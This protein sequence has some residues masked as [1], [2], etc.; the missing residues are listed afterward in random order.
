MHVFLLSG[1]NQ[2]NLNIQPLN[3]N[4]IDYKMCVSLHPSSSSEDELW[5][6]YSNSPPTPWDVILIIPFDLSGIF[7]FCDTMKI[8]VK[9]HSLS[10][11]LWILCVTRMISGLYAVHI[12]RREDCM[13]EGC[14]SQSANFEQFVFK[15]HLG[16]NICVVVDRVVLMIL[17]VVRHKW[18]Q[19]IK[20]A[21]NW[22]ASR[23]GIFFF[24]FS[25]FYKEKDRI[26]I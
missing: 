3:W 16:F 10:L 14:N 18:C 12:F 17:W 24:K 25:E 9:L 8:W 4:K 21:T 5:H 2:C 26:S 22:D 20:M 13:A 23:L 11:G 19:N 6:I 15:R 7:E 1:R